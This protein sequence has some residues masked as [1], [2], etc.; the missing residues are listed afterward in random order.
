MSPKK[1]IEEAEPKEPAEEDLK[2]QPKYKVKAS[3]Q[4]IVIGDFASVVQ[5]Y[6]GDPRLRRWLIGASLAIILVVIGI[7]YWL[8]SSLR[9]KPPQAGFRIAVAGFTEIGEPSERNLGVKLAREIALQLDRDLTEFPS[10]VTIQVL[11]PDEGI[12]PIRGSSAEQ[13]TLSAAKLAE[14]DGYFIVIYG[15]VDV[16]SPVWRITPEFYLSPK[17]VSNLYEANEITGQYEF[18]PPLLLTGQL[19]LGGLLQLGELS[20]RTQ[21]LSLISIGLAYYSVNQYSQALASFQSAEAVPGWE[22][23]KQVLYILSGNA[24]GK[25]GQLDL[26]K[27]YFLKALQVD[28]EYARAYAGLGSVYYIMALQPSQASGDPA[29]ADQDLLNQSIQYYQQALA[30]AHKPPLADIETKAHLGLGQNHTV[31]LFSSENPDF[32]TAIAELSKV[33]EDHAGGENPRV[34][35]LAAEAHARLGLIYRLQ[36]KMEN[37]LQEYEQAASLLFDNPER[38]ALYQSRIQE[39]K[40]SNQA[41]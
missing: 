13:R 4:G 19:G 14:E 36:G 26:A 29:D 7:G 2:S 24:A 16:T 27:E 12:R 9:E 39:I 30:A 6:F 35:E 1:R 17:A 5:N 37:S 3:G 8:F 20:A 28:P 38:Q 25:A 32:E 34:K 40:S 10:P 23:G 11:G 18:G 33:I 41:P 15:M 31:M 21:A 22:D